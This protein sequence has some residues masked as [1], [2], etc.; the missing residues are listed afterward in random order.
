MIRRRRGPKS[1]LGQ[2]LFVAR[3]PGIERA[4]KSPHPKCHSAE[5]GGEN[6]AVAD[7]CAS[8]PLQ[9]MVWR[10]V[11]D[12]SGVMP[13]RDPRMELRMGLIGSLASPTGL[14]S[15]SSPSECPLCESCQR[16]RLHLA[17]NPGQSLSLSQSPSCS[18]WIVDTHRH[19]GTPGWLAKSSSLNCN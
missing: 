13:G 8:V 17:F 2:T 11:D 15:D 3:Q 7:E 19:H 10:I 4:S 16:G 1:Q 14:P 12:D 5:T 9:V 18:G 6:M